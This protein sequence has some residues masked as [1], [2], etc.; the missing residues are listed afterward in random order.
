MWRVSTA[1]FILLVALA[2]AA[3]LQE[4]VYDIPEGDYV[5]DLSLLENIPRA[6]ELSDKPDLDSNMSRVLRYAKSED[7]L[8]KEILGVLRYGK[9]SNKKSVPGVLRFGKRSVPGVLR[10][11]KRDIPGV[12]RFGKKSMPSVLRFGKRHEIP[13]VMR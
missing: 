11:G 1:L 10:F 8:K 5:N 4:Q 9:R 13:G 7:D 3:D 12:L 2:N 6:K